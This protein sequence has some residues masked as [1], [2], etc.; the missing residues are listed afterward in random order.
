[1][2]LQQLRKA[3][4][5]SFEERLRGDDYLLADTRIPWVSLYDHLV[6]TGGIAAAFAEELLRRGRSPEEVCG[7]T[8][9]TSDL[10]LL[11]CLCGLLHDLGKAKMGETE[12]RAHVQRGVDYVEKW[13]TE[14]GVS[15]ELRDVVIGSVCRHHLRDQPQTLL[16]NLVCLADSY[17]SAGD[18]PDLGRAQNPQE[19]QQAIRSTKELERELFEE[20]PPLCLI[21]GDTDAIKSYVYETHVLPEIRGASQILVDLEEKVRELF[22]TKLVEECLMY[23]GGGG[24]LAVVPASMAEELKGELEKLYVED[25]QVATITVVLSE[26]LGYVQFARGLNPHT[27]LEVCDLSGQ[28]VAADLL[29]SHFEA[30]LTNRTNR[31]NFGELI[32]ALTG[33]MQHLKRMRTAAPF[34]ETLPIQSRCESCGKRAAV[35]WDEPRQE[36]ICGVCY[37]KRKIGR[38]GRRQFLDEFVQW[39]KSRHTEIPKR[40]SEGILRIPADL[41]A[42]ADA[43]GRIS[44]IY[45]DGNNVGE[46]LQIMRSPASY[47]HLSRT[48]EVATKD[49]LFEAIWTVVGEKRLK[50]ERKPIPFEIIALGGDDIVVIVP[51]QYGWA[52]TIQI[53]RQFECNENIRKLQEELASGLDRSIRLTLSA[54]L[55]VADVKYPI[56]FLFALAEGLLKKAKQV[57]RE[58]DKGVLC[59]LWLRSPVI[60][61]NAEDVMGILYKRSFLQETVTLTARPYTWEDA[62]KLMYITEKLRVLPASQRRTL[63]ESLEKGV[64]V[65]LNYA[66]YQ[67]A[68]RNE[69]WKELLGVFRELGQ[70]PGSGV[71]EV[72]FW[73]RVSSEGW[74]TALLDALELVELGIPESGADRR[75]S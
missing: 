40:D 75:A 42:L 1:M 45:A 37:E 18:R 71:E 62:W 24:F 44:L 55:V 13:L 50:D 16:E 30:V 35:H 61:E 65:S 34:F 56:A 59:H 10:R 51:A 21:M 33:K 29:Y 69:Q 26:P 17:A 57:A 68:R 72:W 27:D 54:A 47:R 60:S 32:S 58:R 15:G 49:A 6:L 22:R 11:A 28:G 5:E 38:S 2:N 7:L 19:F 66:L 3:F 14:K 9:D 8:L 12:Y 41:D 64:L 4:K 39:T 67:A 46:L 70:L 31:K 63:A 23:C 20:K 25:T 52:L 48:L 74:K 73:R 36:F 53:L 43:E